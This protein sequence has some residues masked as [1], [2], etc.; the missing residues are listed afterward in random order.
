MRRSLSLTAFALL[1]VLMLPFAYVL[2]TGDYPGAALFYGQQEDSPLT[3]G[4]I[5]LHHGVLRGL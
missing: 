5:T 4:L 3:D 2:C 1:M